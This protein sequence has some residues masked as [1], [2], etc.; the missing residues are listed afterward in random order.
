MGGGGGV[1]YRILSEFFLKFNI[2]LLLPD[3]IHIK[4]FSKV[5]PLLLELKKHKYINGQKE[6]QAN[7]F[8]NTITS[9]GM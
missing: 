7:S 6:G 2:L 3:P 1:V 4:H 5:S 8:L 9:W